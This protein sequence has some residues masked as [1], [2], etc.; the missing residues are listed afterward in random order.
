M[1]E[2]KAVTKLEKFKVDEKSQLEAKENIQHESIARYE[3][4]RSLQQK[5]SEAN[6]LTGEK[7]VQT[8]TN[9][10]RMEV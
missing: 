7:K 8:T 4:I 10:A 5:L 6:K 3:I 2:R 9:G 1:F